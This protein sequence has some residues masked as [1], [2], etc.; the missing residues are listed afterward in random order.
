MILQEKFC[1]KDNASLLKNVNI[2]FKRDFISI[3]FVK[4]RSETKKYNFLSKTLFT[5]ADVNEC[6]KQNGGCSHKCT[7]MEGSYVCSCPDPELNLAPDLR[8]CVGKKYVLNLGFRNL[9]QLNNSKRE[10]RYLNINHRNKF[11]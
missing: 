4:T 2:Y 9:S 10:R 6:T 7:N 11:N 1:I 3:H 5:F 8:T